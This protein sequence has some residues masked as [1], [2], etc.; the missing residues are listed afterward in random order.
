VSTGFQ[1]RR[2]VHFLALG[3]GLGRVPWL[4]GTF[5]TLGALPIL[6][7]L[8]AAPA[9]LY[10][11]AT[12]VAIVAGVAICS[13]AAADAGVDDDPAIVWDEIAG[14][15]VAAL[16]LALGGQ[17]VHPVV[18]TAVLFLLFR[19]L[20]GAKVGPIRWLDR[21][22]HGGLGIMADDVAAGAVAAAAWWAA[23]SLL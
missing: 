13:R 6:A 5:G 17:G 21:N 20:D 11:L 4:P 10:L 2:P 7:A 12:A 3:F 14:F 9:A 18:D 19:L 15:L 8:A 23:A 22:L 16:P 1:L